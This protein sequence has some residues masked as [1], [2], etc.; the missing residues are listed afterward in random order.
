VKLDKRLP[1][2]HRRQ[3]LATVGGVAASTGLLYA[4]IFNICMDVTD[5]RASPTFASTPYDGMEM[6]ASRGAWGQSG[7]NS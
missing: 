6:H 1:A 5:H 4:G 2:R 3:G 7:A